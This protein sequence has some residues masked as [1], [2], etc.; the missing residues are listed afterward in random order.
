MTSRAAPD[1]P[2]QADHVT[3][4]DGTVIPVRDTARR[5]T[6][7]HLPADVQRTIEVSAGSTVVETRSTG[8]GFTPGFASRL[9]LSDGTRIFVKAASTADDAKHGWALSS[10][11]R[12]E[13]RKLTA[14]PDGIGAPAL[15]WY[16]DGVIADETWVVLGFDYVDGAP[17]RRPWRHDE[18]TLVLDKLTA[19]AP[20]LAHPPAGLELETFADDFAEFPDWVTQVRARD[21]DSGWLRTVETLAHESAQRC[22]GH[23]VQHLDLR[24]DNVLLD[25]EGGVWICDWNFPVLGAPWLDLLIIVLSAEGDGHD[26]DAILASHPL[27][28]DVEPRSFDALLALVWLYFTTHCE[29]DVPTHSP[30]LRDHQAWYRDVTRAWLSNRLQRHG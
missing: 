18:L 13:V 8:V 10:A 19:T 3:L 28:A 17:P 29:D 7:E 16:V 26:V 23:S 11:Y 14:L 4:G 25:G 22:A 21:G 2:W 24:D 30:H 15:R 20:L 9:D 12:E 27:T 1:T 6:W 5:P